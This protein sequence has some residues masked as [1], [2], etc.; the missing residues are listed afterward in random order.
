MRWLLPT[1][2]AARQAGFIVPEILGAETSIVRDGWT[3]ERFIE[4]RSASRG[5][6][7]HLMPQLRLLHQLTAGWHQRPEFASATDLISGAKSAD[8]DLQALP[9]ALRA[10]IVEAWRTLPRQRSVVHGDI[11]PGNVLLSSK[12]PVLLDWDETR[13]DAAVF[14]LAAIGAT[15]ATDDMR[16]AQ[17]WEIACCWRP[18]PERAQA[19]AKDF[20]SDV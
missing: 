17:A 8:V 12:G 5:D 9:V 3:A 6:L 10:E 16:A 13:V 7:I 14:D 1:H 2:H 4:G 11:N 18:E 15:S 20:M 19:L